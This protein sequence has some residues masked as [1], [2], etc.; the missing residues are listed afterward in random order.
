MQ[1]CQ[2]IARDIRSGYT[3]GFEPSVRDG[4]YHKLEVKVGRANGRKLDVRTR[5]GYMAPRP[6]KP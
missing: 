3:I 2:R 6:A 5:T 1:A 4:E